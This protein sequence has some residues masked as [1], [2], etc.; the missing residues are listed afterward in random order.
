[1]KSKDEVF[2]LHFEIVLLENNPLPTGASLMAQLVKNPPAMEDPW[3]GKISWRRERLPT[4]VFRPG[5]FH[6]PSM[7]S[8]TVGHDW[9][10]S[11]HCFIDSW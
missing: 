6:G 4:P 8:H 1:M 9:L 5:E 3:V 2:Q 10:I 11:T 7:G